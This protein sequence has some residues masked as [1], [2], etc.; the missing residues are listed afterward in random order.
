MCYTKTI[1]NAQTLILNP[2]NPNPKEKV[3]PHITRMWGFF[4]F[5]QKEKA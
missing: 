3:I 5:S 4:F 1:R 2:F